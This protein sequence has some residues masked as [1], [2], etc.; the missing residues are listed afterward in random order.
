MKEL[1]KQEDIIITKADKGSAI[2]IV[3]VK[4]YIK[5]DEPKL[6]HRK[7]HKT[8]R[9][10]DSNEHEISKWYDRKIQKTKTNK[11]KRCRGPEKI[12]PKNTKILSTTKDT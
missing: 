10:P 5:E 12:W 6:K 8:S 7:L 11:C 2:V 3:D 9:R 1:S 4:D